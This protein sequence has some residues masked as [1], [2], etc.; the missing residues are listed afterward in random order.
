MSS[1]LGWPDFSLSPFFSPPLQ[2]SLLLSF[3][4]QD[5]ISFTAHLVYV[6]VLR[7]ISFLAVHG[8]HENVGV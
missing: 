8:F 7:S 1:H 5:N 3:Q 4:D 2:I 6:C